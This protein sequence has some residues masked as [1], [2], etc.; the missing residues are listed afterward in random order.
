M[1]RRQTVPAIVIVF[2]SIA[3]ALGAVASG[4]DEPTPTATRTAAGVPKTAGEL[5]LEALVQQAKQEPKRVLSGMT[6]SGWRFWPELMRRFNERFKLDKELAL[7]PPGVSES[8]KISQ[9]KMVVAAGG[10]PQYGWYTTGGAHMA[11]LMKENFSVPIKNWELLLSEINPLVK[12]G[13][14]RAGSISPPFYRGHGFNLSTRSKGY[15]YNT[16]TITPDKMPRSLREWADPKYAGR[17]AYLPYT[18]RWEGYGFKYR[19]RK[20]EYLDIVDRIGKGVRII[21]RSGDELNTRLIAGEFDFYGAN[22]WSLIDVKKER[23]DAPVGLWF[24]PEE[25]NV[26]SA[27]MMF[28]PGKSTTPATAALFILFMTT[29]E[30]Q[31]LRSQEVPNVLYGTTAPDLKLRAAMEEVGVKPFLWIESDETKTFLEWY[32]TKEGKTFL[33]EVKK[34]VRQRK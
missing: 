27:V 3:L 13:Q 14:V 2:F 11:V 17:Y 34:R 19:D 7:A 10:K 23:P 24:F 8:S 21:S 20:Q 32:K 26:T 33:K 1:R 31:K 30:A 16:D 4:R 5:A 6:G 12:S 9:A 22:A 25:D 18:T 28:I 15:L 29:P